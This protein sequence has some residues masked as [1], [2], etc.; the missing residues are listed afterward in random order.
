MTQHQKKERGVPPTR[1]YRTRREWLAFLKEVSKF[2]FNPLMP[3]KS[4]GAVYLVILSHFIVVLV[5]YRYRLQREKDC[6][7]F[8]YS[9]ILE[10]GCYLAEV[11]P[12]TIDN[13]D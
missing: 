4:G 13:D 7:L 12:L 8:V 10:W 3:N 11:H 5:P 1:A 6:A 2:H 9:Q